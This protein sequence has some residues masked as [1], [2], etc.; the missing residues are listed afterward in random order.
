VFLVSGITGIAYGVL[1]GVFPT[2]ISE[3]FGLHGMS[4][5]W[6]T[7]TI[8]AC[9]FSQIFNVSYGRIFDSHSN[10][11]P[12]KPAECLMGIDC[13]RNAYYITLLASIGGLGLTLGMISRHQRP[14][15]ENAL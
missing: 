15:K 13:Y 12:G 14:S 3:A 5:N 8:G 11:E 7:M 1:F 10:F 9:V 4:Q 6:G 2:I